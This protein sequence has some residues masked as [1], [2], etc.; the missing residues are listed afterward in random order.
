MRP[1]KDMVVSQ[2]AR[3]GKLF[4]SFPEQPGDA[5]KQYLICCRWAG[6]TGEEV[7]IIPGKKGRLFAANGISDNHISGASI[8]NGRVIT[9]YYI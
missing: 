3:V 5:C 1:L 2:R 9:F 8:E 6:H 4:Q 7:G